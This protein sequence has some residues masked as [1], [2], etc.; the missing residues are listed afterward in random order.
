MP[1]AVLRVTAGD[2]AHDDEYGA[3]DNEDDNNDDNDD[4]DDDASDDDNDDNVSWPMFAAAC[5]KS[6]WAGDGDG[7][8]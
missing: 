2:G 1:C 7:D 3:R 5:N 4:N 6:A 8:K